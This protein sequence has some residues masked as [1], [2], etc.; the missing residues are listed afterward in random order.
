MNKPLHTFILSATVIALGIIVA[1]VGSHADGEQGSG[2]QAEEPARK[3]VLVQNEKENL[4]EAAED[5]SGEGEKAQGEAAQAAVKEGPSAAPAKPDYSELSIEDMVDENG[6][7][8]E[9]YLEEYYARVE[10]MKAFDAK[11]REAWGP[12]KLPESETP[13][14]EKK[15]L[16]TPEQEKALEEI[17]SRPM[18]GW[19]LWPREEAVIRGEIAEDAPHLTL[20]EVR[21]L[22][23]ELAGKGKTGTEIDNA[24]MNAL[25]YP[26]VMTGPAHNA[27]PSRSFRLSGGETFSIIG[28]NG[29]D[30]RL[31]V[32]APGSDAE[33]EI[34]YEGSCAEAF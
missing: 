20:A 3:T 31:Q 26:D 10:A 5:F 28:G 21:A 32:V 29:F 6:F 25:R 13:Q 33:P 24:L 30:Y 11:L 14:P 12:Q 15:E 19:D 7:V 2:V 8:K 18:Y 22:I 16:L 9:E 4:R 23:E 17:H 34:L 27:A 1:V